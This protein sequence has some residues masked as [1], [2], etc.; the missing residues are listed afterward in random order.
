MRSKLNYTMIGF[1]LAT[2]WELGF[3]AFTLSWGWVAGIQ[4]T[5]SLGEIP[6]FSLSPT[7]SFCNKVI[8]YSHC[9]PKSSINPWEK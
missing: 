6:L 2:H 1:G 8:R 9:I 4:E 7:L 3:V 5:P